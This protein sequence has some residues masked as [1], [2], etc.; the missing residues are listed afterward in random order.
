MIFVGFFSQHKLILDSVTAYLSN[1]S[2]IK[3]VIATSD[4]TT[5]FEKMKQHVVH[6]LIVNMFDLSTAEQNFII[7]LMLKYP[8]LKILLLSNANRDEVILRS[9]KAGA[10]G[11]ITID[12]SGSELAQAIYTLRMGHDY[13]SDSITQLL[14]NRYISSNLT[15]SQADDDDD[16]LSARQIE[17]LKLWG[18]G[19]SN[20]EIADKLFISVRT[21]ETHKN[22][23]MQKLNLKSTVDLVKYAI[24]SNIIKL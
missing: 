11:Y 4:K 6:V 16:P 14:L 15:D 3:T 22:H 18:D 8:K 23:I 2:D 20:Q 10:K 13:Y 9:I 17:I 5:L 24:K 7:D 19:F 21:V 1:Y 12:A